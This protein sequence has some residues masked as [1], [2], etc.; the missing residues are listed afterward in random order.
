M[1]AN[2][3]ANRQDARLRYRLQAPSEGI[4]EPRHAASRVL[5]HSDHRRSGILLDPP[6]DRL[7]STTTG[8][9]SSPRRPR[10]SSTPAAR[11][12]VKG[13]MD[14]ELAVDAM[15]LAEHVDQMVLFSG[16]GDFRSLVEAVQ[17][18][19]A[20]RVNRDLDDFEP[21]ADDRRR[22]APPGGRPS[23]I[24]WNCSPSSAAIPRRRPPPAASPVITRRSSCSAPPPWRQGLMTTI[25][26]ELRERGRRAA[27]SRPA[28]LLTA[29]DRNCPLCPRLAGVPRGR[30]ARGARADMV[31]L[32]GWPSFGDPDARLLI[33]GL[34]PGLQGANRTGRPVYGRF[35]PATSCTRRCWNLALPAASIRA[36]PDDGL[37]PGPIAGSATRC[38]AC[39]RRTSRCRSRSIL[40]GSFCPP[41]F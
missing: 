18:S 40:A 30:P 10:N 36:R 4:P 27:A 26:E 13:N 23:P 1:A 32:A 11:R 15:E 17:A 35:L 25:F 39:R 20:S 14:I 22:T 6:A 34:A 3:Y 8:T 41:R 29:P 12:K 38:A 7:G 5:L 24:W 19:R 37:T 31:Q 28:R 16:D 2:L 21:A 33:V 9:P